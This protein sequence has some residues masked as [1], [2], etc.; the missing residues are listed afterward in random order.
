MTTGA[1]TEEVTSDGHSVFGLVRLLVIPAIALSS[2]LTL[3]LGS[4]AQPSAPAPKTQPSAPVPTTVMAR[5]QLD[6]AP[7][8]L[9]ILAG[10]SA[11]P[12]A[13]DE[14]HLI[15]GSFT[16]GSHVWYEWVN[17]PAEEAQL[18]KA[19]DHA[20]WIRWAEGLPSI[21]IVDLRDSEPASPSPRFFFATPCSPATI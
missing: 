2:I 16:G 1:D 20:N 17:T 11:Q 14:A 10:S 3:T 7:Y 8:T 6:D 13:M 9:F 21:K 4:G 12:A 18:M 19:L 5:G 15:I